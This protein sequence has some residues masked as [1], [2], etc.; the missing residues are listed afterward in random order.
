MMCVLHS[1][2]YGQVAALYAR[3]W[4]AAGQ[5]SV[6]TCRSGL[7]VLAALIVLV[8]PVHRQL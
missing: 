4:T 1:T 2:L 8:I 5:H 7:W 6:G 3:P